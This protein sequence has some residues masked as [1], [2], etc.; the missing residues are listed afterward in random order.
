MIW[1]THCQECMSWNMQ[2]CMSW[3][4]RGVHDENMLVGEHEKACR[5]SMTWGA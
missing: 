5:E 3:N 1:N 2:E 4:M